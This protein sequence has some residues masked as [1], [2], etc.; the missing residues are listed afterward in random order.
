MRSLSF[1]RRHYITNYRA[2]QRQTRIPARRRPRRNNIPRH[3][4][5]S[6]CCN[7]FGKDNIGVALRNSRAWGASSPDGAADMEADGNTLRR[8]RRPRAWNKLSDFYSR[9]QTPRRIPIKS[10]P[11]KPPTISKNEF[12]WSPPVG[13]RFYLVWL[14][15]RR[16][17]KVYTCRGLGRTQQRESNGDCRGTG[18]EGRVGHPAFGP[19]SDT[20]LADGGY[21]REC[22]GQPTA[23]I[24]RQPNQRCHAALIVAFTDPPKALTVSQS[25]STL[26]T[27]RTGTAARGSFPWLAGVGPKNMQNQPF[28]A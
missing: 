19:T 6:P 15:V 7:N 13:N 26:P 5:R 11:T 2:C 10:A 8:D 17:E 14:D 20:Y 4:G 9:L 28:G 1:T 24:M 23:R 21:R 22:Q 18:R 27:F 16:P 3:K 12:S 25:P